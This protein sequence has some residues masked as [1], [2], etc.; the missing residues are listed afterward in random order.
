MIWWC[1]DMPAGYS[2]YFFL[3]LSNGIFRSYYPIMFYLCE[4]ELILWTSNELV[5]CLV[6]SPLLCTVWYHW[7]PIPFKI[8]NQGFLEKGIILLIFPYLLS[9]TYRIIILKM[10]TRFLAKWRDINKTT[11]NWERKSEKKLSEIVSFCGGGE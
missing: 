2:M 6:V 10:D 7:C 3:L 8:Y 1:T 5:L 11:T 4:I 9:T